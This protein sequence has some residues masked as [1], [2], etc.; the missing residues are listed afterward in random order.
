VAERRGRRSR[1]ELTSTTEPGESITA[2]WVKSERQREREAIRRSATIRAAVIASISTLVLFGGLVAL[3]VSSPGWP[4]VRAAFFDWGD[5]KDAFPNV[6]AGFWVNVQLF[7]VAEP[8]IL[9]LALAVA[10]VRVGRAPVL[11]PL[12]V[13]ATVYTDVFRGVPT[14][15]VVYLTVFGIPALELTG[16]PTDERVLGVIALTLSYGAYVAEVLRAGIESVHPSQR[17]AARSL[18]LSH[19]QTLRFVVVPQ[20]VRRV[21]PPLLNDFV[22]LQKDTALLAAVGVVESLREA[23]QIGLTRFIYTPYL[24][25]AAFFLAVTIPLARLTDWMG[26]RV[27]LRQTAPGTT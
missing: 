24:V 9:V 6:A 5:A 19:A 27:V 22:S 15:L 16:L 8:L 26:R 7:M 4:T 20:A 3:I 2:G 13:L 21:L 23:N 25:T 11:F 17:S 1:T 10:V 18:G 14:L 12:R